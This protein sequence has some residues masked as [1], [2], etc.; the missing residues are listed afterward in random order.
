MSVKL[1]MT[2]IGRHKDPYF[3]IVATDSRF[4]RDGRIIEQIGIFDPETGKV[5]V[6]KRQENHYNTI[7]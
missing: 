2:K 6:D 5:T 1:R 4:A 3:R 7:R